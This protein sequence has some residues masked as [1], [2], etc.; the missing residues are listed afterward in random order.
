MAEIEVQTRKWGNS[1]GVAIPKKIVEEEFLH[2]NQKVIIEIKR[3]VDLKKLK[4]LVS[5]KKSAQE[6]KDEMKSGWE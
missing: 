3:V 2:E 4:G 5:F 6:I 1:L